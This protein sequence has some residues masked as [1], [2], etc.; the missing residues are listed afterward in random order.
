VSRFRAVVF[1]VGDTLFHAP[2]GVEVMAAAGVDRAL[3]QRLWDDVWTAS[4]TAEELA[5]GRD[6]SPARHR[7]CW[8]GLLE[9]VEPHAPGLAPALYDCI[10]WSER[11]LPYPDAA[12]VLAALR[13]GGVRVGALSNIPA[14]L[15]PVFAHHGL[16]RFVDA[17]VESFRYAREKPDPELFRIACRELCADPAEAL[18]V[19]D[20]HLADGAAVLAGMTALLLPPRAPGAARG[21]DAVLALCDVHRHR[22][23]QPR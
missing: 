20:S 10:W 21:L 11:W 13:E 17:Y 5:K 6:L 1:D 4:K 15:R 14:A 16:A 12:G 19:G 7:A 2:S 9:R 22:G 23:I 8:L 3:A 18:M